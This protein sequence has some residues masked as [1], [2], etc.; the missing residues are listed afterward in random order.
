MFAVLFVLARLLD[1]ADFGIVG[2]ATIIVWLSIFFSQF[3]LGP[4]IVQ[5]AALEQRHVQAAVAF[6]LFSG[7]VIYG[8]LY[9]IAP[10]VEDFFRMPGLNGVLRILS[11]VFVVKGIGAVPQALA[12]R[13]MRFRFLAII[14]LA[15]YFLGYV[16]CAILFAFLGYG[17]FALVA[18]ALGQAVV[19]TIGSLMGVHHRITPS[20]QFK[21]LKELTSFGVGHTVAQLGN[22][23]A[24]QGD[25]AVVGRILGAAD[26]GIYSRAYQL[27]TLPVH[28]VGT[29]LDK[30]LFP[31]FA[32]I[33]FDKPRMGLNYLR[34]ITLVALTMIP[35]SVFFVSFSPEIVAIVLGPKWPEAIR[36]L[37][38]LFAVL[39]FRTAYKVGDS[40]ALANGVVYQRALRQWLYAG[41]IVIF[42]LIG[43]HWGI[44]GVSVGVAIAV[45]LNWVLMTQLAQKV[46]GGSWADVG[47]TLLPGICLAL[48]WGFSVFL[49]KS[50][51]RFSTNPFVPL[52]LGTLIGGLLSATLI[53]FFPKVF[54][55]KH[56]IWFMS[57]IFPKTRLVRAP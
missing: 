5:R 1:P 30:I 57:R 28:L 31:V 16:P 27:M 44:L 50:A 42:S 32:S 24:L 49:A 40:I 29:V 11:L 21:A 43:T 6:S 17:P 15:S 20:L 9:L 48:V 3:G 2:A 47:M 51:H 8:A 25:N 33:Q 22:Y 53:N 13:E 34:A 18:A 4:A 56:G 37:Q 14:N 55:G 26:L 39:L 19:E 23:A 36:P 38:I 12:Q 35:A 46:I 54:L 7:L 10:L 52:A 45:I 41:A